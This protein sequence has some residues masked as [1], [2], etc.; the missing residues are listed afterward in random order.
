MN[1]SAAAN[2]A[3]ERAAIDQSLARG[4]TEAVTWAKAG[5]APLARPVEA[6]PAAGEERSPAL[7]L[8]GFSGPLDQLLTLARG[9]KIDLAALPLDALVAQLTAA[10]H[11]APASVPL[12]Q[13][14]DWVVMTAWLVQL[15]SRLLLPADA[16]AQQEAVVE[17]TQLR[18]RLAALD[19]VQALAAW[20]QRQ[21]QLGRDV[22]ARGVPERFG[23]A[24]KPGQA[25]DVI[26]FLWAS[27]ALFDPEPA[28]AAASYRPRLFASYPVAEARERIRH[29][30]AALPEGAALDRFLPDPPDASETDMRMTLRWRSA[31]SSTLI[32]SLELAKQGEVVL[33]QGEDFQTIH[34]GWPMPEDRK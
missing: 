16:P 9:Q 12:G 6:E 1:V 33:G 15:R 2:A 13:K 7:T 8:D 22:F 28:Q 29:R 3:L 19:E 27:L 25:V 4:T 5:K 34:V 30:L 18:E 26:A 23:R 11:Q 31:W 24:S 10:L 20:L 14:A 17:A 21:P 32:A